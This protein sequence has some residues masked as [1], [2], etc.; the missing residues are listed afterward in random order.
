MAEVFVQ[1]A[2]VVFEPVF[3]V[4]DGF[5]GG[6]SGALSPV[7]FEVV[8]SGDEAFKVVGDFEWVSV[9][10]PVACAGVVFGEL[11]VDDAL[12]GCADEVGRRGV[13]LVAVDVVAFEVVD[14]FAGV[15]VVPL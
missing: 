6:F 8:F 12:Q 5:L 14:F 9:V 1:A 10:A 11:L 15:D 7:V 4:V 13:K 2:L 3:K